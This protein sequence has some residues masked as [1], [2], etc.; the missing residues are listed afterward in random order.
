MA[1]SWHTTSK[2]DIIWLYTFF[3]HLFKMFK[4]FL[5]CPCITHP[6]SVELQQ[7]YCWTFYMCIT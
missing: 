4:S 5:P 1:T 2:S 6:P 3:T 7:K